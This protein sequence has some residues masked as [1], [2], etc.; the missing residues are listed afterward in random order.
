MC[1]ALP[2]KHVSHNAMRLTVSQL[3]YKVKQNNKVM[4]QQCSILLRGIQYILLIL[5]QA[6]CSYEARICAAVIV[7][8]SVLRGGF[9][10][11]VRVNGGGLIGDCSRSPSLP[12]EMWTSCG[13]L[14]ADLLGL[15]TLGLLSICPD[16]L[17]FFYWPSLI[18]RPS[19][20]LHISHSVT[21]C[22]EKTIFNRSRTQL[23]DSNTN[24]IRKH[25]HKQMKRRCTRD[26]KVI[27]S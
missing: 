3:I 15:I 20:F 13:I 22:P 21:V 2:C 4:W 9:S 11:C 14:G 10:V 16:F 6:T 17:T 1:S 25:A 19:L 27:G 24:V 8:E 7:S 26:T 12:I 5:W 23:K 18:P